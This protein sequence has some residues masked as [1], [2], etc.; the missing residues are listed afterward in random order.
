MKTV[1][2]V[3]MIVCALVLAIAPVFTD[4]ESHGKMLTTAD[5]RSMSMKCHWAGVAEVAAAI[6]LGIA[7]I[8]AL[9]SRRK[10]TL[11]FA[12]IVGAAS[13]ADGDPAAHPVDRGVRQSHDDLQCADAAHPARLGHPGDRGQH[14]PVCH[15]ARAGTAGCA[16][17]R[18]SLLQLA[19]KNISGN[20]LRS[21]VVALCALVVAAFAL[22][23]TLLL[24]GAATSLE[25]A[26]D[27]LGADI[28][29]VPEGAQTEME[30]ALLMGVPAQFWMPAENVEKLAAIPGVEAVS[31]QIYL[32]TLEGASCCS[33]SQM[34]MIAYD[35]QTDFTVRPW[36]EE[37]HSAGLGLGEVIGGDYISATE[38]DDGILVYGDLVKL[39]G[40][41]EP[42]GTG[43]DQ[44]LFFTLDTAR[45][46]ARV[47]ETQAEKPLVIPP[48]QVS[49]VLLKTKPGTDTEQIAVDIYRT[50]PGVYPIQSANLFQS[51]RTQLNSLLNTVVIVMALIWPLAI[52]LIG[53]VYLMAANERRREL[54]V[55]RA[56]G[57]HAP[58][59]RCSRCLPRRACWHSAA[60]RSALFL[61]VLAIYL[62]RR[63]IMTSLGVPF[64][65]PSPG[66]LALQIGIGLLLAMFSVFLA[67]L[68]PAIKISRQ[69][70]AIAMRE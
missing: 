18:M 53:M 1:L 22:F 49:A 64:L 25:L 38:P 5:G 6:P 28:V 66:S 23:A 43:L 2:G 58:L 36:L 31:P 52:V 34:F 57:R 7:G 4:C 30:G 9:R 27:R 51:S 20:G 13:G 47:S 61:A 3:V 59:R 33:V 46:I 68:L 14:R 69:D 8:Y 45:D 11:R 42:T 55:L 39:K 17:C 41:L 60:R 24:R 40:N 12:G 29:V 16:G 21:W 15:R 54:G 56:L 26:A 44:S 10:E 63:L 32:A 35:P 70:P 62:F 50:V 48:D 37:R 67:A 65:L 19:W